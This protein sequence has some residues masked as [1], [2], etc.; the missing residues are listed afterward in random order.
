MNKLRHSGVLLALVCASVSSSSFAKTVYSKDRDGI[1]VQTGATYVSPPSY[2]T[3]KFVDIT[4]LPPIRAWQPGDPTFI[5]PDRFRETPAVID[6]VAINPVAGGLDPLAKLQREF[7]A[8]HRPETRAPLVPGLSIAG[9]G[10]TGV[11]PPDTSGDIGANHFV[12]SINGSGGALVQVYDKV[13]GATVGPQFSMASLGSGGPC[14]TSLGDPI[15]VYDE[16]ANRWVLTE[17]S[18]QAGRSLCVYISAGNSP[19][20]TTWT[21]YVF[22]LGS[23]P[24]YPKYGVWPDAYY[25]GA[26]LTVAGGKGIFAM[27]RAAMLAGTAATIQQ[28]GVPALTGFGFQMEQPADVDGDAPPAGAPGIFM[29]HRDDEV[30]NAGTNNPTQDFVDYWQMK[31]DWTTPANSTVTGPTSI[32]VTEFDSSLNGLTAF[33]AFPQPNAQKLDPLREPIMSRLAYRNFGSYEVL[34]GNFVTDT[35][36][37]DHGGV[38]WFELRR[39]GGITQPWVKF[40]EGTFAP[41]D[42]AGFVNRW[43]GGVAMDRGGNIALGYS[44]VRQTPAVFPSI[45]VTGRLASDPVGVMSAPE[46]SIVAGAGS[47]TNERWGDYSQMG[48]DPVD[49]CTFWFNSEY[50]P[51]TAWATRLGSISFDECRGP[52]YTVNAT[53][54]SQAICAPTATNVNLAPI[55]LTLGA[56]NGFSS[57]VNLSFNPA[58]PTGIT[59]TFAPATVTPPGSST[60]QLAANNT[61][62]VGNNA[63][64]VKALSGTIER[65]INVNLNVSTLVAAAATLTAPADLATGVA[66]SPT[67]SWSA[68]PQATSY[69]VEVATNASFSNIV[70]TQTITGGTNFVPTTALNSNTQYFWR[71]RA[72]NICGATPSAV[73]SFRTLPG[74]GDCTVANT[75]PRTVYLNNMEGGDAGWTHSP[76]TVATTDTWALVTTNSFSPTTSW[77]V[78][79]PATVSDQR[80]D[81]TAIA[82]PTGEDPVTL[83]FYH[84][85]DIENNGAAACYDGGMLQVSI[86]GGTSYTPVTAAQ[87][88]QTPY[89]GATPAG[90]AGAG[91]AAWCGTRTAWTKVIVN[92]ASFAG[93]S[94]KLRYRLTSDSSVS[95]DGW[96]VD[97]ARVQSCIQNP[98]LFA[99]GFE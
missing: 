75:V 81:S 68:V 82:I 79:D 37:M 35:D 38:R 5:M 70:L 62:A 43:M 27:D 59:G 41:I 42:P 95:R 80:L 78:A 91:A 60:L 4:K 15:V 19:V 57:A 28:F 71:V 12:L 61:A 88:L 97:D 93:Q 63:L 34:V 22:T 90:S 13:T 98:V 8:R 48:I 52:T 25:V 73:F 67:F 31:I 86:D 64:V 46:V 65:T 53:G 24:D 1:E 26:N 44:I 18:N 83:Q 45:N 33:N 50:V 69:L 17:F 20:A 72:S 11:S 14:A 96:Y 51:A 21:R 77:K 89:Q 66:A 7:D 94:V 47:Q 74:P 92:M 56:L 39:T 10:N 30:H 87:I 9:I 55:P 84:S 36:A 6:P 99:D 76:G 3:Q 54:L 16:L 85:Y 32:G 29:R 49:G 58:L 40:Q 2:P 23:F